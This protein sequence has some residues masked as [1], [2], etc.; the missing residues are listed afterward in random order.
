VLVGSGVVAQLEPMQICGGGCGRLV[1]AVATAP[2]AANVTPKMNASRMRKAISY[3]RTVKIV[4]CPVPAASG[5]GATVSPGLYGVKVSTNSDSGEVAVMR[6]LLPGT[7]WHKRSVRSAMY[8]T[9][10]D[11]TC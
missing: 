4:I 2:T 8:S 11:E 5:G 1:S 9:E 6:V 3:S 7:I 10:L